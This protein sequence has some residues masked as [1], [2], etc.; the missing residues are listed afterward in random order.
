M[1]SL[2]SGEGI[3]S[4]VIGEVQSG[5]DGCIM[6]P[7]GSVNLLYQSCNRKRGRE[8]KGNLENVCERETHRQ[9]QRERKREGEGGREMEQITERQGRGRKGR[10]LGR[11]RK[12]ARKGGRVGEKERGKRKIVVSGDK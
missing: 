2:K 10:N 9:T 4:L 5:H 12:R 8:E 11:I 7:L 3:I 6:L 1:I